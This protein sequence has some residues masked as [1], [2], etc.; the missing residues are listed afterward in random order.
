MTVTRED[1]A[2]PVTSL[3]FAITNKCPLLCV[4][5]YA[6]SG[7]QESHGTMTADDWERLID[8]AAAMSVRMIQFIGGEV[9]THPDLARL[10][11]YAVAARL[12]V[13][14][15]T[16]MLHVSAEQWAAFMLPGV[17]L[18]TSFYTMNRDVHERI[19][20]RP[21]AHART[22]ANITEARRR[23]IPVR[24]VLVGIYD[25]QDTETARAELAALG[26]NVKKPTGPARA[27]GR[28]AQSA[29]DAG[30]LCG[31]CGD[32]RAA[33]G[34]DG[35]VSPCVMSSS[36]KMNAGSV[37]DA[38]LADIV[39]GARMRELIDSIPAARRRGSA[40]CNPDSDSEDCR[41]AETE[42][43]GPEYH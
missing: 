20:G 22:L 16:N 18:A 25:D 43:C 34:P 36:L 28:A 29:P 8:E 27:L 15:F 41:P 35:T 32:G 30:E 23:D 40:P 21:A 39:H 42:A 37:R 4:H 3:A 5:C 14:V 17:S 31:H 7:P 19:T 2:T 12:R 33:I 9:T 6:D 1:A 26:V 24:A 10:I 11:C 13:E 38:P